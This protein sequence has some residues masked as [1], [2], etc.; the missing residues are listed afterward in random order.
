LT[1]VIYISGILIHEKYLAVMSL[2]VLRFP[3]LLE[4]LTD[5]T[6]AILGLGV[7]AEGVELPAHVQQFQLLGCD[8][9]PGYYF[10]RPMAEDA[11]AHW[12]QARLRRLAQP[13][14]G[15]QAPSPAVACA[16]SVL[17]GVP[18]VAPPQP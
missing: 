10:A 14:A 11:L 8:E 7:V 2:V 4:V 13:G 17:R 12:L 3:E 6:H 5:T 1:V 15:A 18:Q 9:L 16:V